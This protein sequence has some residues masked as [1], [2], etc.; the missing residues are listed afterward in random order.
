MICLRCGYCCLQYDV[1]IVDDPSIGIPE[2]STD[3]DHDN[4]KHKPCGERCQHLEGD[5]PG[6]LSCGIHGCSWYKGTPCD[7]HGQ[8]E[9]SLD[10]PCRLGK[11]ILAG[12]E[13]LV[14]NLLSAK[15]TA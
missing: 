5:V 1:I 14:A 13:R 12:N 2:D 3:L 11:H 15:I 9:R 7:R 10:T 6:A 8:W 4:L